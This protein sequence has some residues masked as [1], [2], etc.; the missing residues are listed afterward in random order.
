M[1][2]IIKVFQQ[3]RINTLKMNGKTERPCKGIKDTKKNQREI[4]KLQNSVLPSV[5]PLWLLLCWSSSLSFPN[6]LFHMW[7]PD[8]ISFQGKGCFSFIFTRA[9]PSSVPVTESALTPSFWNEWVNKL[10]NEWIAGY[11][12]YEQRN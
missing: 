3:G 5:L 1:S 9:W 12:N 4:S 7:L 10:T 8:S 6:P 11:M 2:D